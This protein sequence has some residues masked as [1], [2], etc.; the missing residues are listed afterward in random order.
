MAAS[1]RRAFPENWLEKTNDER[2]QAYF[3]IQSCTDRAT[4]LC[5][6]HETEEPAVWFEEWVA[7]VEEEASDG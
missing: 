5:A 2:L 4:E 1:S 6:R 7:E 3:A